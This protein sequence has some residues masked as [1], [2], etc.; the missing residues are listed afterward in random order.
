MPVIP[1]TNGEYV[2]HGVTWATGDPRLL[3][4]PAPGGALV[5][6]EIMKQQLG[7]A[8]GTGR[9]C[10]G[11]YPFSDTVRVEA[12]A[13][14][15]RAEAEQSDQCGR[16]FRQDEFRSAHR[17]HQGGAVSEALRQ[18]MDQPHRLYLATFAEGTTK[19]GTAAEPRKQSRLD[20]QGAIVATYLT[21][22]PNGEAVRHLEEAITAR[23]KI[24]QSVRAATKLKALATQIDLSAVTTTH[25]QHVTRAAGELTAMDVPVSLEKWTPPTEGALLRA[26]GATRMLYP[27][28]L[29]EGEHGFTVLSCVGTQVLARLPASDIDYVLDLGALKGRRITFGNFTSAAEAFQDSLF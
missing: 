24:P 20:E 23:L 11:R 9:W 10:T 4:A 17:I 22:S 18:Y 15:N 7:F 5:Y 16:C 14:P 12:V 2:C 19:V 26:P 8:T 27:H 6:S 28:D 29:R 1:P 13:C 3:L 25:E 21:I